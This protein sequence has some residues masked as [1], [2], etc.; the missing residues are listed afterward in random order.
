VSI[1]GAAWRPVY[2]ED[3]IAEG[4]RETYALDLSLDGAGEHVV[5]LRAFDA[6]GN[7]GSLRAVV[8]R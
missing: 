4:P 7:V 5:T 6:G 2:P 1:D 3:G 8:R